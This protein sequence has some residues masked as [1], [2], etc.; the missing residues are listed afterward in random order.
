MQCKHKIIKIRTERKLPYFS[1]IKSKLDLNSKKLETI[2]KQDEFL[3]KSNQAARIGYWDLDAKKNW[4]SSVTKLI[5]HQ[6]I[7]YLMSKLELIFIWMEIVD[8]KYPS[9]YVLVRGYL[10]TSNYKY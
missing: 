6:K 3:E 1:Y 2:K 5:Q 10:L 4:W 8:T 9:I 7:T